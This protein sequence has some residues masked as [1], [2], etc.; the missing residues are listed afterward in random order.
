MDAYPII[1]IICLFFAV[2]LS[3][4]I[5]KRYKLN[6]PNT[7]I[8]CFGLYIGA[9]VVILTISSVPFLYLIPNSFVPLFTGKKMVVP[10]VSQS[11]YWTTVDDDD[12]NSYDQEMFTPIVEITLTGGEKIERSLEMSAGDQ[13]EIV[14]M[15]TIYYDHGNNTILTVSLLKF[16]LM[17]IA[18]IICSCMTLFLWCGVH[19]ARGISYER[20]LNLSI[21]L[22]IYILVPATLLGFSLLLFRYVYKRVILGVNGADH[23]VFIIFLAG[24][25]ALISAYGLYAYIKRMF[26]NNGDKKFKQGIAKK[27]IHTKFKKL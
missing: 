19:Y 24:C 10:I 14:T 5:V 16:V 23:P 22:M 21:N 9:I 2:I 20:P 13:A 7:K 11:S 15:Q 6:H 1:C 26:I 8:G 18:F 17:F 27:Q 3:F 4:E 12:G 25:F